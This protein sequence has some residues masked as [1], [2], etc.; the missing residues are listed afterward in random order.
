MPASNC[1]KDFFRGGTGWATEQL[2][3]TVVAQ[4]VFSDSVHQDFH[5]YT[6]YWVYMPQP[7]CNIAETGIL[8]TTLLC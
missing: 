2:A 1:L 8:Y 4:L 7:W 5:P 6:G 3:L